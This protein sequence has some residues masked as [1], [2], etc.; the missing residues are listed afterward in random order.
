M[1]KSIFDVFREAMERKPTASRKEA[2][3]WF[4]DKMKSD[5]IFLDELAVSYFH[6]MSATWTIRDEHRGYSFGRAFNIE[7]ARKARRQGSARTV[8]AI[9]DV[10]ASIRVVLLDLVLPNGKALRHA[11]GVE[12]AK[13]G[14][15]YSEIAKHIKPTQV[16]DRHLSEANLQ[17]IKARYFQRN[18][19][20]AA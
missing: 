18:T 14:G 4:V 8:A 15:F 17:D 7:K 16:V 6:R 1:T 13:A 5:P 12:C 11:T 9:S 19:V 2:L 3:D 20:K 10:K